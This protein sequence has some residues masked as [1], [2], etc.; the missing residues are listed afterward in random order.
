MTI[1]GRL[2]VN[3]CQLVQ[4]DRIARVLPQREP[5]LSRQEW[6]LILKALSAYQHNAEF[7]ALAE[8]L[9]GTIQ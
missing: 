6:S 5:R 9:K 2:L 4:K 1:M 3:A 7:R 8:R